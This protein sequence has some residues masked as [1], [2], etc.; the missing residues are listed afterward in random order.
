MTAPF[1]CTLRTVTLF[2]LVDKIGIS[3]VYIKLRSA[4]PPYTLI[5]PAERNSQ[6]PGV[7]DPGMHRFVD[8]FPPTT[9]A[10]GEQFLL[11]AGAAGRE[12]FS[13]DGNMTPFLHLPLTYTVNLTELP[14]LLDARNDHGPLVALKDPWNGTT[15]TLRAECVTP[16]PPRSSIEEVTEWV[17][18][19]LYWVLAATIVGV[20]VCG[21]CAFCGCV[22]RSP[23][24][25]KRGNKTSGASPAQLPG[26][27]PN[28]VAP[29]PMYSPLT[30]LGQSPTQQGLP[31]PAYMNPAPQQGTYMALPIQGSFPRVAAPIYQGNDVQR[32]LQ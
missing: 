31:L 11:C 12:W 7:E 18:A 28:A 20:G 17:Q 10:A 24:K 1:N 21:L 23:Q 22:R 26:Q 8:P 9:H 6:S 30:G 4:F 32:P 15:L 19:H 2:T 16:L 13:A 27:L 5:S 29:A 25:K 3:A 14:I